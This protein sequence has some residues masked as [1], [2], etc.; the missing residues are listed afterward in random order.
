MPPPILIRDAAVADMPR[1]QMIYAHHVLHG[2]ASFE[3]QAPGLEEMLRRREAVLAAGLPWLVAEQ[4]GTVIGY[5]YAGLYRAR[6]AYRHTAE[7]SIYLD[8]AA[9]GHG[10]GRALLAAVITSCTAAGYRELIAVIGD[11]DNAASIGLHRALGFRDVGVLRDVGFK[12]GRWLDSV[13]MQ[14][15]INGDAGR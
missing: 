5:A 13:I 15:R 4:A 11:S 3:E 2:T 6:S 12:F 8:P 14:L 9:A 1:L 7:D 10:A